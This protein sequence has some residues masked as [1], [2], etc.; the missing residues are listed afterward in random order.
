MK[1]LFY[2]VLS[3]IPLLLLTH[4]SNNE[5]TY[6]IEHT[7]A[8]IPIMTGGDSGCNCNSSA[9]G[10]T[11]SNGVDGSTSTSG[12][13]ASG[14]TSGSGG[15][16]AGDSA[17]GGGDG[18]CFPTGTMISTPSGQ[19]EIQNMHTGD[20]VYGFNSETGEIIISVV[21]ETMQHSSSEENAS[22]LIV[23]IHEKGTLT[24]TTNH[25][26]YKKGNT[27]KEGFQN[28]ENAGNLIGGDVLITESGEEVK[29]LSIEKGPAYDY[30]YNIE[31]DK[32]HTYN[33]E[34][35]RVHNK[36]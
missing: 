27:S 36:L 19:K 9:P 13:S 31:V 7:Y 4:F 32:V 17:G 20:S 5:K 29:I 8:D 6:L 23:I 1:K 35:L 30:V 25:P 26:V 14:G 10:A 3:F 18:G 24:L 11:S 2:S 28:F 16:S 15:S 22:P 33:A 12:D 21:I 34:G